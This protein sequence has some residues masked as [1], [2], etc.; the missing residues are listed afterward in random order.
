MLATTYIQKPSGIPSQTTASTS[1]R[2]HIEEISP[3]YTPLPLPCPARLLQKTARSQKPDL[4]SS[5]REL[6]SYRHQC[7]DFDIASTWPRADKQTTTSLSPLK[8]PRSVGQSVDAKLIKSFGQ[9]Q[10]QRCL[11]A[12]YSINGKDSWGYSVDIAFLRPSSRTWT[13]AVGVGVS[14]K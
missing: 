14:R 11:S 7:T 5:T 4:V 13:A 2:V 8:R 12:R 10:G 9:G 1:L 6:C 3:A